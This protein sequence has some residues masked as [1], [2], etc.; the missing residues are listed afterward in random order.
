[1]VALREG[2]KTI[3]QKLAKVLSHPDSP[4]RE[5]AEARV[6]EAFDKGL[7][8]RNIALGGLAEGMLGENWQQ[9]ILSHLQGNRHGYAR[10]SFASVQ[11]NFVGIDPSAFSNITGQL[12]IRIVKDAYNNPAFIGDQLCQVIPEPPTGVIL[13][14]LK[15]PGISQAVDGPTLTLP[16]E[17]YPQTRVKEDWITLPSI[18]KYGEI[19]NVTLEALAMDRTG[20]KIQEMANKIGFRVG[21]RREEAILS[22]VMG[23]TN[24][25]TWKDTTYNTYLTS[26]NWVNTRS[27]VDT[28]AGTF[29][30]DQVFKQQQLFTEILDPYTSKPILIDYAKMKILHMPQA[31][32]AF[33]SA[34]NATTIRTG[35]ISNNPSIN[36]EAPNPLEMSG[37]LLTSQY[38]FNLLTTTGGISTTNAKHYW[39]LGDFARSFCYREWIAPTFVAAPPNN[40][41][42]FTQDIALRVK[43]FEAGVAGVLEPRFTSKCYNT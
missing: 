12:L 2:P 21:L 32:Y 42:E 16:G 34:I 13:G 37:G 30:G 5:A 11:E 29:T 4:S 19:M 14:D 41:A 40:E 9:L 43:A 39:W 15:V 22:V 10:N 23:I 31:G 33:R 36:S 18:A 27:G 38:A 26:G 7:I 17:P 28:T 6:L 35:Q 3:G 8:D 25:F 20:G 1:M 24:N